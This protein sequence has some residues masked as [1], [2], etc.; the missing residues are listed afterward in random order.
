MDPI[1]KKVVLSVT[2]FFFWKFCFSLRTSQKSR[3]DLPITEVSVFVHFVSAGVLFDVAFSLWLSL[4]VKFA[5][6]QTKLKPQESLLFLISHL[7]NLGGK[8]E[9]RLSY[10]CCYSFPSVP[11]VKSQ[12]KRDKNQRYK[13]IF[14][15]KSDSIRTNCIILVEEQKSLKKQILWFFFS[16]FTQKLP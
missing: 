8:A 16:Q 9:L 11:E 6:I 14:S 15:T 1:T 12:G 10:Y 13:I 7:L 3:F 2:I 4:N 5:S